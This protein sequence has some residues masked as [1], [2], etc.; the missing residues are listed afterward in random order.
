M[1][2]LRQVV[3]TAAWMAGVAFSASSARADPVKIDFWFGNSGDIAKRVME[4]CQHF[5]DSQQ[6]YQVESFARRRGV[7]WLTPL[8]MADGTVEPVT[9]APTDLNASS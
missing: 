4:V 7:R 5:N 1:S 8:G 2:A 9:G 3:A 6:D